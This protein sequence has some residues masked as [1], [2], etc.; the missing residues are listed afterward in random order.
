MPPLFLFIV[1][2]NLNCPVNAGTSSSSQMPLPLISSPAPPP[3]TA[4]N[5]MKRSR[6][7]VNLLDSGGNISALSETLYVNT[8]NECVNNE[9]CFAKN[10][11]FAI[12]NKNSMSLK[13]NPAPG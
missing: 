3:S 5:N 4:I 1:E 9:K 13:K 6:T 7:A 12:D 8:T 2:A 10:G 11:Y